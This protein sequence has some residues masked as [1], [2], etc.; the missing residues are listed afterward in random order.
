MKVIY[1]SHCA[2]LDTSTT[3]WGYTQAKQAAGILT[4]HENNSNFRN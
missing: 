3:S 1:F 2:D 4:V